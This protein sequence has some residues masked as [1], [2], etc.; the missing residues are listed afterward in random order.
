MIDP[1]LLEI[2]QSKIESGEIT[3]DQIINQE[4]KDAIGAE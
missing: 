3:K 4:Y 1:T 2:L